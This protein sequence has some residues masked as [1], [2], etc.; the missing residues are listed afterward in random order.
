M[1]YPT[2]SDPLASA[3]R[4]AAEQAGW[5][6]RVFDRHIQRPDGS[7]AG[8][9]SYRLVSWPCV[10]VDIANR[11]NQIL[12]AADQCSAEPKRP[13]GDRCPVNLAASRPPSLPGNDRAP[14]RAP[15]A[16]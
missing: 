14:A 10:L 8:C 9:G 6:E 15:G 3:A 1:T 11:A 16:A 2:P 4:F 13:T 7:C 5:V 12:S